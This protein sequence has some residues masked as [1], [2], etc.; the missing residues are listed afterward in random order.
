MTKPTTRRTLRRTALGCALALALLSAPAPAASALANRTGADTTREA[1]YDLGDLAFQPPAS[2]GYKGHSEL[3]ATVY[4]P[5]DLGTGRHPVVL[6]QHGHWETCADAAAATERATAAQARDRARER[7]DEAEAAR[8]QAIVER[9][10]Q[11]LWA[12]PCAP[13]T[14]QIPSSKGYDYLG[15]AL[16]ARGF[17]VVSIGTN[18]INATDGGQ[19]PTVYQARAALIERHLSLWQRLA[20][21]GDGPLRTA[22]TD[23]RTGAPVTTDFRGRLD[24]NRV[25]LLGHSMGGGG[26]MQEIADSHR[27]AWPA[28][29]SVKAAFALAP[30]ATW[31]GDPVTRTPFAVMWGTCDQVNTGNYF[32]Q[33]RAATRVP[34][35]RY[36]L[37]G[38]N[39][40]AYNRQWSPSSGQ[41]AARDDA[42]PGSRPGTCRTQYPDDTTPRQDVPELTEEQQRLLT[43]HRVTAFFERFLQNDA[44]QQPYLTGE[45]P[46]P[47]EPEGVVTSS[48][49]PGA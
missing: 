14:A 13:G 36:A 27:S 37:T 28:G 38:G 17:V 21:Q 3:A 43:T 32:E 34:L 22:L 5:A 35:F 19:A 47:G 1:R 10:D 46:F 33:N 12:W 4:Y 44:A 31:D 15:H 16:A 11:P 25:G 40:T 41:V 26:V 45:L 23:G 6:L 29:I 30:S 49:A 39:H 7:G 8:W 18:G 48:F 2:L 42:L 9:A 20:A 24:L